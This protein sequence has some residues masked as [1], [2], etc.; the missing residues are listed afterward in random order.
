LLLV[1]FEATWFQ[2]VKSAK[3]AERPQVRQSVSAQC[4]GRAH[5]AFHPSSILHIA[6]LIDGFAE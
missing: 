2:I 5:I 6:K 3:K 1:L 4:I